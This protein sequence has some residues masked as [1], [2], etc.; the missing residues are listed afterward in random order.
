[1]EMAIDVAVDRLAALAQA[2][3]L[4]VFRL[5]VAAGPD[6]V[7]AGDIADTLGLPASS[8]SFHLAHLKRAGLITADRRGRSLRYSAD[9]VA[10]NGLV[11]FLTENCC[12]GQD[13]TFAVTA[14]AA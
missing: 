2:H 1:M 6:G 13:C 11:D 14:T 4:A 5:L 10:I 3:R 8:L 12:G 7:A 9:F